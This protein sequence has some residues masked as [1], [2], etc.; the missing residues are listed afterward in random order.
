MATVKQKL[1]PSDVTVIVQGVPNRPCWERTRATLEASDVGTRYELLLQPPGLPARQHC[2]NVLRRMAEAQTPLVLRLEDD[3]IVNRY[4]LHNLATWPVIHETRFGAG[5]GFSPGN[6]GQHIYDHIFQR[7]HDGNGRWVNAPQIHGAVAT[8]FWTSFMPAVLT[9]VERVWS[10]ETVA[11]RKLGQDIAMSRAV[12]K[13]GKRV[14][15]HNPS[16]VEHKLGQSTLGHI[17]HPKHDTSNGAF[18]PTWRRP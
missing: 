8:L 9:E 11:P 18:H 17:T 3:A 16:L 6:Y 10:K 1:G 15:V 13:L 2:L 14:C 12:W 7:Q 5:W 4:L